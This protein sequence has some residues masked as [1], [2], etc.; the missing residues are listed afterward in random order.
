MALQKFITALLFLRNFFMCPVFLHSQVF[1]NKNA[2]MVE[3]TVF[4]RLLHPVS[5]DLQQRS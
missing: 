2:C 3:I 1:W 4:L 5:T